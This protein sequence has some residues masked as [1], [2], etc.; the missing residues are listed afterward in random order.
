[1]AF[2]TFAAGET[3]T[4]A[5]VNTYL[6]KQAVIVC[7]S[8]TRPA[9]P[10]EGMAIY[11]TDTDKFLTYDGATWNLPKSLAGGA[12]I[13]P[14]QVAT[15]QTGITTETSL[16]GL[17]LAVTVGAS[18]RVRVHAEVTV[19]ATVSGDSAMLRI[20]EGATILRKR[21][22][23][24]T[25]GRGLLLIATVYLTPSTGAHT[26]IATLER[27]TGTGSV[28]VGGTDADSLLAVEDVGGA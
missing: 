6:A 22:G 1:M 27:V 20:K 2:K 17:S 14:A 8:G 12:L 25:S 10:V 23:V 19:G 5:D 7:T 24:V 3:L 11:E 13:A 16:T 28:S 18:R 9:S 26:Y 15:S 21:E 4:A